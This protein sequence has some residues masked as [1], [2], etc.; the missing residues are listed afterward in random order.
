MSDNTGLTEEERRNL[1]ESMDRHR[2]ALEGLAGD[3][4]CNMRYKGIREALGHPIELWECSI[5]LR[6]VVIPYTGTQDTIEER[7]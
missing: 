3:H 1:Q 6:E 2:G 7:V 5:C 4:T